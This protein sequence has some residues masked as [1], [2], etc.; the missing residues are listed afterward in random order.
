M[1][2]KLAEDAKP[3]VMLLAG[4]TVL[5]V[6]LWFVPYA[7]YLVYPIR[8]FVTFI[9]ES[10]HAIVAIVTGGAVKSLTIASD[11]SG[12]VYSAS[13]SLLGSI[14]TSSAGYLGTTLFGVAL[15]FMIRKNWSPHRILF[16]C[17]ALVAVMTLVFTIVMPVFN[18][19]SLDVGFSSVAFTVIA[20][21]GITAILMALAKFSSLRVANF[22][23]G[24]IAVQCLLNALS[25]LKT[26]LLI[27]SPIGGSDISNDAT[28]M[29]NATGIP[30]FVWVVV[31]IVLAAVFIA[32]GFRMYANV[33]A[34]DSGTVFND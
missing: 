4:A 10:G 34:V 27:N 16:G 33:K 17:G 11:G 3:Q 19:L 23:V 32:I 13:S 25:D 12:V 20:G 8:L 29:A 15:L 28:N 6:A 24:F 5:T 31:W 14:F 2:Y 7:E 18:F 21:V 22:A 30:A 26:V 1:K 9:H